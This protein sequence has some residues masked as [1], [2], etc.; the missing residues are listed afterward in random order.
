MSVS[1]RLRR[2]LAAGFAALVLGAGAYVGYALFFGYAVPEAKALRPY[3]RARPPV[4]VVFTSRTE[5]AS[6]EAPAPEASGFTYPGTIPWAA[7]EGR[8]R[9]LARDGRVYELTWGRQLPG[10]GTLIDVISPSVTL[11]GQRILFA[12][13]KAP[14][15]PG[16]WRLYQV[17]ADGSDLKQLTGGPDD[18]GCVAL[19]PMRFAPDGS[20][21]PDDERRRTD[22]DDVD[23]TDRGDGTIFFASSR[24]PDLG[25]DHTRRATQIWR[26]TPA[27]ECSPVSANRNNDRWPVLVNGDWLIWSLWSRNRESVSADGTGIVPVS[28]GAEYA[29]RPADRWMAA[30]AA[31]DGIHFGYMVKI[32]EPVWRPRALFNGRLAFMTRDPSTGLL[33]VAQAPVGYLRSAPSSLAGGGPLPAMG[34]PGLSAGPD[35]DAEGRSLTVGCPSPCPPGHVLLAAGPANGQPGAIGLWRV[36]D[37]WTTVPTPEPLFDDPAFVD[38]EPVAVYAR[39]IE[40]TVTESPASTPPP[41][42]RQSLASGRTHA[43]PFGQLEAHFLNI[44]LEDPIPNVTADAGTGLVITHPTGVKAIVLYGAHRDRFDDPEKPRERGAWEKLAVVPLDEQQQVKTW[45]PADPLMPTVLAG[46][47]E[48]GKVFRWSSRAKDAAGKSATFYAYAGDHYSGTRP[49]GYVFCNG[50]HTGHTFLRIDP[51]ERVR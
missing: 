33:R 11:D 6:F 25:R 48:D 21:L 7:A 34:G 35:R 27:G 15:D 32:P 26:R 16:R 36:P 9:L 44:A 31:P 3:V 51:T 38:A 47:G 30:R 14:P 10:G 22:Y 4:P 17:N 23:P 12:G 2:L 43:G 5:P 28:E 1:S 45:V 42:L 50:C 49:G 37:E 13:R 24:I 20:R 41:D 18:P 39:G 29:T 46:L 8:L 19:P 40:I